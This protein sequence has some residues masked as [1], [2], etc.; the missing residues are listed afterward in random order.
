[1]LDEYISGFE[2]DFHL[3]D[4]PIVHVLTSVPVGQKLN[5][6]AY[7][8]SSSHPA[9]YCK[10][11]LSHLAVCYS[12]PGCCLPSSLWQH[13][14]LAPAPDLVLSYI[15]GVC[16][17]G[18][19]AWSLLWPDIISYLPLGFGLTIIGVMTPFSLMLSISWIISSSSF[20]LYG[21]LGNW[22][23]TS[24][25]SSTILFLSSLFIMNSFL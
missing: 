18:A 23:I 21:C 5:P 3:S 4:L 20:T 14:Y 10:Q 9:S 25:G 12:L 19:F 16:M 17:P 1:M 11:T 15:P 2:F 13:F 22:S 24:T 7:L 8:A 6:S